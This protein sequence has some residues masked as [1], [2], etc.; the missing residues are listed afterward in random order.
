[1]LCVLLQGQGFAAGYLASS[2]PQVN[3][4]TCVGSSKLLQVV[5]RTRAYGSELSWV[6]SHRSLLNALLAATPTE[7]NIVMAGQQMGLMGGGAAGS[8]RSNGK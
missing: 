4:P 7:Q 1:M 3:I 6:I 8:G 2:T 5:L